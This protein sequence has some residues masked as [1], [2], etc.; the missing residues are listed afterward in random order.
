MLVL[1]SMQADKAMGLCSRAKPEQLLRHPLR[2]V[3]R[4]FGKGEMKRGTFALK[5]TLGRSTALQDKSA[6]SLSICG[7]FTSTKSY[8]G[9]VVFVS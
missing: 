7:H 3:S 1:S 6:L 2:G 8:V 5:S 4:W 9:P